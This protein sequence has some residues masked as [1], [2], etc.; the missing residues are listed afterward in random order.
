M[1]SRRFTHVATRLVV[2]AMVLTGSVAAAA[3][4]WAQKP[5]PPTYKELVAQH[6]WHYWLAKA[7]FAGVVLM[8]LAFVGL[9]LLKSREFRANQRRG[10]AK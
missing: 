7:L 9:Y 5:L 10:G 8:V 2:V 6:P 3:P 4:A 1:R